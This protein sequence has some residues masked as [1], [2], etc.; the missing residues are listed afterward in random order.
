MPKYRFLDEMPINEEFPQQ[1]HW[2]EYSG[3]EELREM[4]DIH[5]E[6]VFY[7]TGMAPLVFRVADGERIR[8]REFQPCPELRARIEKVIAEGS[9]AASKDAARYLEYLDD[10]EKQVELARKY[11]MRSAQADE[12]EKSHPKRALKRPKKRRR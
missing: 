9:P 1:R 4:D 11:V 10:L 5:A 3:P 8:P 12:P 7:D 2:P 6:L